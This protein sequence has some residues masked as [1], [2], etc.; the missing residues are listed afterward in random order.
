MKE[1]FKENRK[2]RIDELSLF[3]LLAKNNFVLV[4]I[5]LSRFFSD[6]MDS[7]ISIWPDFHSARIFF[8]FR[9]FALREIAF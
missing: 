9:I 1:I 6:S 4:N 8:L 2:K 7:M 3:I 5:N